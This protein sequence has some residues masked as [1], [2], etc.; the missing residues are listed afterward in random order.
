[1]HLS[2]QPNDE[3]FLRSRVVSVKTA[4]LPPGEFLLKSS[5]MFCRLLLGTWIAVFQDFPRNTSNGYTHSKIPRV[6][7][8]TQFFTPYSLRQYFMK[9]RKH[10]S[11]TSF[12]HSGLLEPKYYIN[13]SAINIFEEQLFQFHLRHEA[14]VKFQIISSFQVLS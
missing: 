12:C 11:S 7:V 6:V 13:T 2:H 14:K 3:A 9:I 5:E 10:L 8:S 4:R 1:M